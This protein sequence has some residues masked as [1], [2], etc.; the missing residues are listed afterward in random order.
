VDES[1]LESPL[2]VYRPF[3]TAESNVLRG[4]VDD[5][6]RLSEM[7]FFEQVPKRA[8][9]TFDERGMSFDMKEPTDEALRAAITQFR[10]LYDH[11]EPHSFRRAVDLLKRS[12]HEHGG[13]RRD[14][15]IR[16]LDRYVE[17][18]REILRRGIGLGIVF[19]APT[20]NQERIDVRTIIDAYF[21]GH[22]LHTG[23]PKSALARRLDDLQPWPR[24][25]LYV[26]MLAL[27]NLYWL[28]ANAAQR[29][30]DVPAL[31]D[32]DA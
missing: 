4:F 18:E 25:T 30:L 23:N 1:P 5:V 2:V 31:L 19:E 15:A 6:R 16:D 3:T 29:V 8:S 22:Y 21:H 32:S 12:A 26:V 27:R 9:V 28:A 17:D 10:Q 13:E 11:D 20:G 7:S 14:T 24:Y